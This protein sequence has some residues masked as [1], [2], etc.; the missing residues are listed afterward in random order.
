[1]DN[2]RDTTYARG[3]LDRPP[4]PSTGCMSEESRIESSFGPIKLAER[5][6]FLAR[7]GGPMAILTYS[8]HVPKAFMQALVEPMYVARGAVI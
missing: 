3:P 8:Y 6:Y 2:I 7:K 1:M 5:P 4:C